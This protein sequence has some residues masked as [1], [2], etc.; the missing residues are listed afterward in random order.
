MVQ[1][2]GHT[3]IHA[4]THLRRGPLLP[5]T[6][7][8]ARLSSLA[9][10]ALAVPVVGVGRVGVVGGV[11]E[12]ALVLLGGSWL[13]KEQLGV[14]WVLPPTSTLTAWPYSDLLLRRSLA[15][16]RRQRRER[17]KQQKDTQEGFTV[18][19]WCT[20]M[21]KVVLV[22]PFLADSFTRSDVFPGFGHDFRI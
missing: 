19:L 3:H 1:P 11:Q 13:V 2:Q 4:V 18:T 10:A 15:E 7:A 5:P 22:V 14:G 16:E 12:V 6:S 9:Q 8:Q 21:Q 20:L 17:R